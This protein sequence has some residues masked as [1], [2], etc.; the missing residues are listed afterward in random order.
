M[1]LSDSFFSTLLLPMLLSDFS[2]ST[3]LSS[4]LLLFFSLSS[5]FSIFLLFFSLSS[6]FSLFS[7]MSVLNFSHRCC[8]QCWS[9]ILLVDVVIE[10]LVLNRC[11]CRIFL[12]NVV[13]NLLDEPDELDLSRYAP[14][15]HLLYL[16]SVDV[17]VVL[18]LFRC[19]CCTWPLPMSLWYLTSSDATVVLDLFRCHCCTWPL[20]TV[21]VVVVLDLF[22]CVLS[23][24]SMYLFILLLLFSFFFLL[25]SAFLAIFLLMTMLSFWAFSMLISEFSMLI[26]NLPCRVVDAIDNVER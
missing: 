17:I 6:L 10:F 13:V 4:I 5:S 9:W 15:M 2:L 3:L 7:S 12:P 22:R 19:Y 11:C 18:D 20:S 25:S 8:R 26:L 23:I 24:Q 1:L 16:T 21:G 14:S